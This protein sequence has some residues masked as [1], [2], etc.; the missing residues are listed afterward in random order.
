MMMLMI[1]VAS[2]PVEGHQSSEEI[3]CIAIVVSCMLWEG[4]T[5]FMHIIM[6]LK[7]DI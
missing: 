7:V 6:K 2:I 5:E 1:N 3:G 4:H